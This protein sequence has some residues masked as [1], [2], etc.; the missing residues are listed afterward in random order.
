[1]FYSQSFRFLTNISLDKYQSK[2]DATACLSSIGA[3][4]IGKVKMAFMKYSVTVDEFLN[5]ATSGHAFCNLFKY[6]PQKQY[7]HQSSDGKWHQDYPEYRIGANQGGMKLCMKADEYFWGA[8]TV[9]VDVD[10]TRFTEIGDYLDTLT[11][12]PT[13]V[14]MSFSDNIEKHGR[15]S[16]RF[17]LVYVFDKVLNKAE[18][19]HVSQRITN[20]IVFDTSEPMEDDCGTRMSQYMNGVYGN[21]EIYA[22]YRIYSLSD[23]PEEQPNPIQQPPTTTQQQPGIVFDNK[24]L[25]DMATCTPD[26]IKHYY[27]WKYPYKYRVEKPDWIDGLYQ[28][29]DEN[30]LQLWFY[31]KMQ[32]DGQNRRRKLFTRA[33]MRRLM[34]PDQTPDAA[35]FNLYLDFLHF[36][37]NSDGAITLDCLVRKVRYAFEKDRNQLLTYCDWFIQYWRQNRP[38]YIVHPSISVDGGVLKSIEKRISWSIISEKYDPTLTLQQNMGNGLGVSL[39]TLYRY[40]KEKGINTQPNKVDSE[41]KKRAAK[42]EE[43]QRMIEQFKTLYDPNVSARGNHEL[44][45]TN[46]LSLKPDRINDWAHKYYSAPPCANTTPVE[47]EKKPM[48]AVNDFDR[49]QLQFEVPSFGFPGMDFNFEPKKEDHGIDVN[50]N[51]PLKKEGIPGDKEGDTSFWNPFA[52]GG[53]PF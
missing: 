53:L 25:K 37:D 7:W 6:D 33:C 8:Q 46:G 32:V 43:K 45:L 30:Y 11:S 38:Q 18:F 5:A 26:Y 51:E 36:F 28:F 15:V 12:P 48:A 49:S 24:M 14:Y 44:M 16:R 34:F 39:A 13:C 9:F 1:M 52:G 50:S 40:C 3:K 17:R 2:K 27:S 47:E 31:P 20:K 21:N 35:L 4:A 42:R 19:L 41:A 23:F 22:S 10:Y 29:T